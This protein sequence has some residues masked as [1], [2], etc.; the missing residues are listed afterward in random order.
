MKRQMLLLLFLVILFPFF[1]DAAAITETGTFEV[2][3][4]CNIK[5]IDQ[6]N[7]NMG[8]FSS[9]FSNCTAGYCY[10]V[11]NIQLDPTIL[12]NND[13]LLRDIYVQRDNQI[14]YWY[15]DDE[16]VAK[17]E[18]GMII[19]VGVGTT[20]VHANTTNTAPNNCYDSQGNYISYC[21]HP[22]FY[23]T[24]NISVQIE[25]ENVEK[26]FELDLKINSSYHPDFKKDSKLNYLVSIQNHSS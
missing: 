14:N 23:P 2:C 25:E 17:I 18:N 8:L 26:S 7:M 12:F 4:T 10:Y 9:S 21:V 3:S 24:Y 19:P 5:T 1:V 22:H 6:L 13:S 15:S 11:Y 20:L 16:S